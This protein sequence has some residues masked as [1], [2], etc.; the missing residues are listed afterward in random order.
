MKKKN[1][2]RSKE[3]KI[4]INKEKESK[5]TVKERNEI[6]RKSTEPTGI[7]RTNLSKPEHNP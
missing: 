6:R 3:K 7:S 4:E 1:K 5:M 2:E